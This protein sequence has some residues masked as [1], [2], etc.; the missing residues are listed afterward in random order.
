MKRNICAMLAIMM[1]LSSL[2]ACSTSNGDL[3]AV[4]ALSPQQYRSVQ[5]VMDANAEG[6]KYSSFSQRT[7]VADYKADYNVVSAEQREKCYSLLT[8]VMSE[9]NKNGIINSD[10]VSQELH[11]YWKNLLDDIVLE[12]PRAQSIKEFSG[13]YFLT[14]EFTTRPNSSGNFLAAANYLGL[15]NCFIHDANGEPTLN[16]VWIAQ[17]FQQLNSERALEGKEPYQT[18]V[19]TDL[20]QVYTNQVTEETEAPVETVDGEAGVAGEDTEE[21]VADTTETEATTDTSTD[22]GESGEVTEITPTETQVTVTEDNSQD[23]YEPENVKLENSDVYNKNLRKL[24]YDVTEYEDT[25]GSS[26]TS[27][28]FMPYLSQVYQSASPEGA[29]SGDG[30]YNE[31]ISGLVDFGFDRN[32]MGTYT[33]KDSSGNETNASCSGVAHITFVFKQN[34]LDK[35]QM[36]YVLAYLEDYTSL[37][38]FIEEYN[39]T[40]Y[41]SVPDFVSEQIQIK[42]EEFDRLTNNGDINGLMRMDTVEDAGLALRM[43]QYRN[44]A[45]ITTYASEVKGVLARHG[46]VYLVE[47]ERTIA[48]TPKDTGYVGQ[49]KEKAY[50]VIRQK[51][52]N[53]YINDMFIASRELTKQPQISEISQQYRQ[54]VN[55]N[56]S[57]VVTD[58]IKNEIVSTVLNDWVY[59]SNIRQLSSEKMESYG[60]Y[61][62]FNTNTSVLSEKRLEYINSKMRS[63]LI[64]KGSKSQSVY[65]MIPIEWIGGTEDQVEFITKEFID[66]P[67]YQEGTYLEC[68]Y[69]VSHFGNRWVIDDIQII[70]ETNVSGADY[71]S[72][73]QSFADSSENLIKGEKASTAEV[74]EVNGKANTETTSE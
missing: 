66:Y 27:V 61:G 12:N 59:Y 46:N 42:I 24:E 26:A 3:E 22:S 2:T 30:C 37:N 33:V 8:R 53:F 4:Q 69:L 48:D 15:D 38:P 7:A 23:V 18:F 70:S 41:V 34:E 50:Y 32:A 11:D 1:S 6:M 74:T 21:T 45:D 14:V 19:N 5:E 16:N 39:T 67:E 60:M 64:A 17:S 49:Y 55:L 44:S 36:D 72:K 56:L 25:F 35:E 71:Q 68:Y 51:D 9:H 31:G 58:E 29:I 65:S 10:I 63:L 43:A 73:L 52:L 28:S 20:A 54:L 57:D 13:Y 47:V 40:N 62:Q